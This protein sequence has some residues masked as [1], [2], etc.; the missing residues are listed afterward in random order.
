MSGLNLTAGILANDL[1]NQLYSLI[2]QAND[3]QGFGLRHKSADLAA[4]VA[5]T[6]GARRL[7]ANGNPE[8]VVDTFCMEE[9]A[10]R[11]L[12]CTANDIRLASSTVIDA[13]DGCNNVVNPDGTTTFD[14]VTFTANWQV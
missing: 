2:H 3:P 11:K 8:V 13:G 4:D 7:D 1:S 10:G 5:N 12:G 6:D 9:A 14:T